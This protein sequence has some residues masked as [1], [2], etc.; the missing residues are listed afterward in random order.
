LPEFVD[1]DLQV[2]YAKP[3]FFLDAA[4]Y[5]KTAADLVDLAWY[6]VTTAPDPVIGFCADQRI[7]LPVHTAK[8]MFYVSPGVI[9]IKG[10][11]MC[12][13]NQALM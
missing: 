3:L 10:L 2:R 11:K 12:G 13:G 9:G 4:M 7:A 5:E 1:N 6:P 8:S